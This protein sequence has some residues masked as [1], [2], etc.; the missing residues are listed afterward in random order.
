MVTPAE[1]RTTRQEVYRLRSEINRFER[2]RNDDRI[3]MANQEKRAKEVEDRL[4]AE[5]A[6]IKASRIWRTALLLRK[7][8]GM[9]SVD[10]LK[11]MPW[12]RTLGRRSEDGG[13]TDPRTG[14]YQ[15]YLAERAVTAEK[16]RELERAAQAFPSRPLVGIV[17][18]VH[19]AEPASLLEAVE[20]VYAQIYDHWELCIVDDASRRS[21]TVS[22][23]TGLDRSR[24]TL[25]RSDVNLGIAAATNRGIELTAGEYVVFMD[26]DDRLSVDALFEVVS[27]INASNADFIYSDED[28]IDPAGRRVNP[29]FKPD[30]SPDLLL[31]HNYITHLIAVRRDLVERTGRLR[32]GLDGAQ[33]YDFVLR[34]TE[35]A[36]RIR[37][38]PKVL[39]HWRMSESSTSASAASK[40]LALGRGRRA[41]EEALERRGEQASVMADLAAPH[42]YRVQYVIRGSPRVSILIPFKD[43]PDLLHC[44]VGDIVEKSTYQNFEILA[45]NNAS[46]E[47]ATFDAMRDLKGLDE[48]VR[49]M[50]YDA[51]FNFSAMMNRGAE[52]CTGE[53]LAFVNNDIRICTPEWLEALLE[54]SQ[55]EQVGAVGGKLYY[56]DERVQHAGIIVGIGGYAGHSHK[57]F[58]ADHQGYFN[59]LRV[60]QNVSAVTGAFMMI[61]KR[62]FDSAGGLDETELAV[63]CNDVDLCLRIRKQGL[64]NIFTPYAEA[65]HVESASRG[66]EDTAQ[67]QQR[68]A[69]EKAVFAR[70]HADILR[71]GDPF[72][73]PNLTRDTE[74]FTVHLECAQ[75]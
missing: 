24:M 25:E 21:D 64:W 70:R 1:G 54:H 65:Y 30:F 44:V 69:A 71:D 8:R 34:A 15:A 57:G 26:H 67:K 35:Q 56:P 27:E 48:R 14:R 47:S 62:V 66:Y 6:N 51:P 11:A 29:H 16:R 45:I 5:I 43:K 38:I 32:S 61:K 41:V 55:R 2:R 46:R 73:N 63:A 53:H 75:R 60:V 74:D 33:D 13:S 72:Y 18:P 9:F 10:G 19:D 40:P 17:M 50:D 28:Y 31:S 39:Y 42:F 7:L 12:A 4:R 20:S 59:R 3:R 49:F 36:Q 58:P 22:T 23:L 52:A 37:H 68:F